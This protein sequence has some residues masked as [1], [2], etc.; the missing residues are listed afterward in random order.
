MA[1]V[2]IRTKTG[3]IISKN[4]YYLVGTV[5]GS[6]ELRWSIYPGDAWITRDKHK[7]RRVAGRV[8]GRMIL[9]NPIVRQM[10]VLK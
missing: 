1:M 2:D 7:A 8:N 6:D 9:F 4:G 3:I 5:I 10:K